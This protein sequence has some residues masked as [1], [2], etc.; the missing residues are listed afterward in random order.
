[1][2]THYFLNKTSDKSFFLKKST[3][4]YIYVRSEYYF[5]YVSRQIVYV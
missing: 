4:S 3:V 5:Y 1:M 2:I